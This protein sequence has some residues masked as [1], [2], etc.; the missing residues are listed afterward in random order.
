MKLLNKLTFCSSLMFFTQMFCAPVTLAT[1][2][3]DEDNHFFKINNSDTNLLANI[4]D[5]RALLLSDSESFIVNLPLPSGEL[6]K[7]ILHPE[8][9]MADELAKKYPNIRTFSGK[10]LVNS[11]DTGR[12]DIT[13]NG[14]HGMF[15][16]QGER[17]FVEP[18]NVYIQVQAKSTQT[19][20]TVKK[21]FNS[22]KNTYKSY[23]RQDSRSPNQLS[24]QFKPAKILTQ[25]PFTV[26]AEPNNK[27]SKVALAKTQSNIRTYRIAISAAAEYTE[28]NGG[29]V[30]S[31]MA[32]IVT[33]VNRLNQVYQHDLAIKLELVENNDLLIFTN[34]ATDP[35][36]NDSDDSELN[37][38]VIDGIIGSANY[39]IGHVV[40]TDGGGLAVL[41]SV[42]HSRYKGDGVT[43]DSLP[44]NDAFY[45]D[46]VAHEIG[47]QF[48]AN[49]TFNGTSGACDGNREPLSAYEVGSGSTIMAY[50]GI[51]GDQ[52]LQAHSDAFFHARSI[53]QIQDYIAGGFGST[54]GTNNDEVN[55]TAVVDAGADY[56][57]PA[58]TPFKLSGSAQDSDSDTLMYS[59]QQYDLGAESASFVE[60]V[61]DGSRPL[62]R[63]FLP[64]SSASRYFP[65]LTDV[66]NGTNTIGETLPTTTR[67]L[68]FRLMVFDNDGGASF[69][70]TKLSVIDLGQAFSL[71]TPRLDDVWTES[72]NHI[73]WQVADTDVAPISCASV[74]VLLSK[75]NGTSFDISLATNIAN[76][77][78]AV[79]D[80]GSFCADTINTT[81]A[82]VQLV[83]N[84]NIFFA[85]NNGAFS[86]NKALN[87]S[88][89]S[90]TA[91][92]VLSLVQGSS[93]TLNSAQF[94]YKCQPADTFTIQPGDNY[95]VVDQTITPSSDFVGELQVAVVASKATVNSE[96]FMVSITVEAKP[97]PVPVPQPEPESSSSSGSVYWLLL[98]LGLLPWRKAS[99]D[100]FQSKQKDNLYSQ[101]RN[102]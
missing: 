65:K 53:D 48:G 91:Q 78:S 41:G 90:I 80:I 87:S 55:N 52:N 20:S 54:C 66:L 95:T 86:I 19:S 58:R 61:D 1:A 23:F 59:W 9:I 3:G 81:Q 70:E 26:H 47:H 79:V 25:Q 8:N 85:V 73:S 49:H 96:Q 68:N 28:F 64:N 84:D 51:C 60:Q 7:F 93:I 57:I 63:A 62:F 44:T 5:L 10:S 42:C 56:Y 100:A 15:Y 38:G 76:N 92:P 94:T 27:A 82:R 2:T 72:S 11:S 29:T 12:F 21:V 39:D 14:F 74:D 24:H 32:E 50:A 40:N 4:D 102:Y 101:R 97:E 30:D 46:Y 69:D 98:C 67:E 6:V 77:G 34:S 88:D 45:I 75:D 16:Y 36:N 83:C 99:K 17:I 13:D 37:T 89:V 35:F 71:D 33:L 22:A 18:E 31:A 43:G